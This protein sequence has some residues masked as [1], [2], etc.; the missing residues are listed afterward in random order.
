MHLRFFAPCGKL[1]DLSLPIYVLMGSMPVLA[2][3]PLK[4]ILSGLRELVFPFVEYTT[5]AGSSTSVWLDPCSNHSRL[6][7]YS[8]SL[9][10]NWW[11]MADIIV[12]AQ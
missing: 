10:L 1:Q 12:D 8:K 3:K 6:T 7:I 11:L 9:V 2:G 5:R 4:S